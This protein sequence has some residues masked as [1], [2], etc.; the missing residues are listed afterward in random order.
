MIAALLC[1]PSVL[2]QMGL[3]LEGVTVIS[4]CASVEEV[5]VDGVGG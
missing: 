2:D 1:S 5:D 4:V 3:L